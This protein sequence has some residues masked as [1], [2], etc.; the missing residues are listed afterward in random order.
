MHGEV[1]GPQ[2]A[3]GAVV[4]RDGRLLLIS[5]GRSPGAGKWSLPGGRVEHG[6]PLSTTVSRE[7]AEETGMSVAVGGLCGIAERWIG[8]AHFVIC[9]FWATVPEGEEPVAGDDAAEVRWASRADLE[10]LALVPQLHEWLTAHGVA[11]KLR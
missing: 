10:K 4:L 6:E 9:N 2:V 11:D 8:D 3:A 5:R 7:L 1:T